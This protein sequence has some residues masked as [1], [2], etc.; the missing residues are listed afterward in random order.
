MKT[1]FAINEKH[2][3]QIATGLTHLLADTY[4]PYLKTHRQ[5]DRRKP[6]GVRKGF[7]MD[8]IISIAVRAFSGIRPDWDYFLN[9]LVTY[10]LTH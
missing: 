7:G 5:A 1:D 10:A 2:P 3:R 9:L 6:S 8:R 4:S